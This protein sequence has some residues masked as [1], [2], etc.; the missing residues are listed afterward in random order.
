MYRDRVSEITCIDWSASA[1]GRIHVDQEVDLNQPLPFEVA[2][3]DTVLLADVL[4]HIARPA[5]LLG[6]LARILAPGGKVIIFVPFLYRVHEAPYDYFRYTEF[7]LTRLGTDAGLEIVE[8]E[9][10]GGY[11]D[12]LFDLLNKGLTGSPILCST[13]LAAARWFSGLALHARWRG[14]TARAYPLGYCAVARR[15]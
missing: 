9:P 6:E 15:P 8:I 5:A 12:A 7:A 10:Y 4:E 2:R 13:F 14:N 11:P 3:F 1:H